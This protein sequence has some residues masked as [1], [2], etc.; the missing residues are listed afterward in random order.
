M[1]VASLQRFLGS[2]WPGADVST[3]ADVA[4]E[5]LDHHAFMPA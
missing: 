1:Q 3:A 2:L 5:D 4:S